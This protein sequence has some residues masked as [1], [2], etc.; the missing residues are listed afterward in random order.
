[1]CQALQLLQKQTERIPWQELRAAII[2]G[3][4]QL[5]LQPMFYIM[6]SILRWRHQQ[7]LES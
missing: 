2:I 1:M 4:L 6:M 7:I 5:V 3:R